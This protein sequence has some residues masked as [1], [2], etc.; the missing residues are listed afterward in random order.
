MKL[1]SPEA[2]DT[3]RRAAAVSTPPVPRPAAEAT[4][5]SASE[6]VPR[7]GALLVV[8]LLGQAMSNMDHSMVNVA[9][10]V[11]RQG[12]GLSG[13]W[14]QMVITGYSLS[15]AV[16]LVTG[17]RLGGDHGPRRLFLI[18]L[19]I[20]TAGSLGCSVAPTVGALVALRVV[21]GVGAAMMMPQVLSIIQRQYDGAARARALGYYA[22]ILAVGVTAGQ[23]VGGA[24]VTMNVF[25]LSW[26]SA[27][28]AHVVVGSALLVGAHRVLPRISMTAR[29]TLDIHGVLL[30]SVSMVLLVIP[31]TFGREARW[32]AW[33]WVSMALGALGVVAFAPWERAVSRRGRTPLLDLGVLSPPGVKAGLWV[34]FAVMGQY[35]GFLFGI[36]LHLQSGLGYTPIAS[37]L[38]FSVY[39]LGFTLVSLGWSRLPERIQRWTPSGG[40]LAMAAANVA[41][42]IAVRSGWLLGLTLPLLAIAGAGHGAAFGPLVNRLMMRVKPEHAPLLSGL[43]TTA[44]Q[45]AVVAGVASLGSV[46]LAI[47]RGAASSAE[48]LAIVAFAIAALCVVS[49][50]GSVRVATSSLHRR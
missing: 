38:T 25:G 23:L 7:G 5:A 47:A 44:T 30:L 3:E 1:D 31:L 35:G 15:Y 48:A 39:A 36:T 20:L 12:L 9:A 28:L 2:H 40:L 4:Q 27:F 34:V 19:T 33:T 45:L 50:V 8:L 17:A 24:L 10:P 41:L 42:G 16:L 43:L 37:G 32:P 18:G 29:H 11:L 22:M 6:R 26:R 13:A 49:T 21:Q 46:Y 14:L